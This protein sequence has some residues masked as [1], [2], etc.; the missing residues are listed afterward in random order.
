MLINIETAKKG[1]S[2]VNKRARRKYSHA[3]FS[4]NPEPPDGREFSL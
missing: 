1:L 3:T 2:G 4:G